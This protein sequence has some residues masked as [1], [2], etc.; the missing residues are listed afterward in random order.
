MKKNTEMGAIIAAS[1]FDKNHSRKNNAA[2]Q[3][4]AFAWRVITH[5]DLQESDY[6][7]HKNLISG[8]NENYQGM[9]EN[10]DVHSHDF[11]DIL[12][13]RMRRYDFYMAL[14]SMFCLYGSLCEF[15]YVQLALLELWWKNNKKEIASLDK[16]KYP[17]L[18]SA[19]Q[20]RI[21]RNHILQVDNIVCLP[22]TFFKSNIDGWLREC[23]FFMDQ[24]SNST[25]SFLSVCKKAE[26]YVI[27]T[28]FTHFLEWI[29]RGECW[30]SHRA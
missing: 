10:E 6:A 28:V 17:F 30:N 12:C 15:P 5:D 1:G 29:L 20:T 13:V 11:L 3:K 21:M 24:Q 18:C 9:I 2:S 27:D 14:E 26:I 8:L 22:K 25:N 16:N 4:N 7:R 19:T 23:K